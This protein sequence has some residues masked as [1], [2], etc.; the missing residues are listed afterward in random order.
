MTY[1]K[2]IRLTSALG[3]VAAAGLV[4]FAPHASQAADKKGAEPSLS[5]TIAKEMTA[6]QKA[7]QA[8]QWQEH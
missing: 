4:S 2:N 3:L 6:A 8:G 7:L 1:F 5:R